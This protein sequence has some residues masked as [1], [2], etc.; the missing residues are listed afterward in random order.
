[1]TA[2]VFCLLQGPRHGAAQFL[3]S[4]RLLRRARGGKRGGPTRP[5]GIRPE[6]RLA[7]MVER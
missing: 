2:R 7:R 5:D 1:M 3:E 4:Q 6:G